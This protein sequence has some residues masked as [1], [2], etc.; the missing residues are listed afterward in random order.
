MTQVTRS[1]DGYFI[2]KG[3]LGELEA[4]KESTLRNKTLCGISNEDW[5]NIK[6]NTPILLIGTESYFGISFERYAILPQN[7]LVRELKQSVTSSGLI[8]L[9]S[10]DD[11]LKGRTKRLKYRNF[12]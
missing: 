10:P 6:H 5:K 8:Y 9:N 4:F 1:N 11:D 7:Y 2:H 12:G 3:C